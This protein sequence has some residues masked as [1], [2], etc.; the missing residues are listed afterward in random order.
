MKKSTL[1]IS[2]R[3]DFDLIGLVAPVKDYKMA[4]LIN[5]SLGIRLVKVEDFRIEF[6]NQADLIVSQY[7]LEKEH[8]YIQLL[9]NR[10]Y[11]EDGFAGYLLPELKIM[12]YFLLL[13]DHAFE[14]DI[15]SYIETLSANKLIQNV[16][17]LNVLKLKS[18]ENLLTY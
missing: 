15:N 11:S 10:A 17:K 1:R 9:K 12:D 3:Y 18:K 13:E 16:V 4:W 8:G 5:N 2:L 6:L 14:T 7:V